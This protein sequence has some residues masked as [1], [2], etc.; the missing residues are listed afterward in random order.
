MTSKKDDLIHVP[1]P[2]KSTDPPES[3]W[4]SPSPEVAKDVEFKQE[5]LGEPY[6]KEEV[7]DEVL[8][9]VEEAKAEIVQ[10]IVEPVVEP[11][12]QPV[13]QDPRDK[14]RQQKVL[15]AG[16]RKADDV[17][18]RTCGSCMKRLPIDKFR[19]HKRSEVCEDCE[20]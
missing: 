16:L 3:P 4:L 6:T 13:V 20:D 8:E 15:V 2:R 10:P 19:R 12:V 11:I 9:A 7:E 14:I 5:V 17:D 18:N 1:G